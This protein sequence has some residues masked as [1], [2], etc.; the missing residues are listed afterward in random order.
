M[1]TDRQASLT[2]PLHGI[3]IV[4]LTRVVAG[5]YA[6]MLLADLGAEVIKVE[7]PAK[8]DDG[9]YGYPT[10][11]GVPLAFAALNRN[12]KGITLDLRKDAGKRLLRELVA[13]S[14]V[15]VENFS[16]GTMERWGLGYR[17]LKEHNERLV[18][19][20]LSG[21]GHT[22]PYAARTSYDIIAQAMG[23]LMGLTGFAD[24]PPIRGGGAL[25][26]F[27]GGLLTAFAV[28]CAVRCRE[29]FGIGQFVDVSNMD[30][31]LSM[32]DNWVTVT[33]VTGQPPRRM[34]NRHPFTAP[35]DCFRARDGWVVIAVG[36]SALFR[37]L[38][39]AIGR[40]D[41]GRD[42]RFKSPQARLDNCDEVH[43]LV[44]DWVAGR[45]VNEVLS[46]LGPDGANVPCAPVMEIPELLHD[47]HVRA[48]EMV[49]EVPDARLGKVAVAGIPVKFAETPGAI[50]WLG[51]ELGEH[52][53]DVYCN[54]L[55]LSDDELA[56]L[57]QDGV[58]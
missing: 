42:P 58:I 36:N 45:T 46:V 54:L 12:K 27:I 40:E 33:D 38:M 23:G 1:A 17:E 41:L 28:V 2:G 26:D 34:G 3:R 14:D 53:R 11:S 18:Y 43:A 7:L 37:A 25:G 9:R 10:V 39:A 44:Q 24:G 16:A 51:P 5:P 4:D 32:T 48:R 31:I 15:L 21:F 47:P 49:V 55:G 56:S 19:V 52:N 6:T 8:G 57:R 50:R 22:G 30:A 35:Y 13:R 29:Q 20:A